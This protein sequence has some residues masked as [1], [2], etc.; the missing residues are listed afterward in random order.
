M[1]KNTVQPQHFPVGYHALHPDV[2]MNFQM[3][4]F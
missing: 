3:N 1:A 2:A 4:R